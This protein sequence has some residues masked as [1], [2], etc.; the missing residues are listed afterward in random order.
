MRG[1]L[2]FKVTVEED[3][4]DF[5]RL[6]L[7]QRGETLVVCR[8]AATRSDTL[9]PSSCTDETGPPRYRIYVRVPDVRRID[10]RCAANVVAENISVESLA[11]NATSSSRVKASGNCR[12]LRSVVSESGAIEVSNLHCHDVIVN[13]SSVGRV[14]AFAAGGNVS[15]DA[16][17]GGSVTLSGNCRDLEVYASSTARVNAA[18]M[19][20]RSGRLDASSAAQIDVSLTDAVTANASSAANINVTGDTV[21]RKVDES[22]AGRVQFR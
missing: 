7:G 15:V 19:G 21:L 10:A 3:G 16:A 12:A 4:G 8:Q 17:S 22:S 6:W 13:A 18:N 9:C 2:R 11:I 14:D 20:C 1:S 5:S